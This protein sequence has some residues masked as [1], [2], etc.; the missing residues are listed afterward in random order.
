MKRIWLAAAMAAFG[1]EYVDSGVPLTRCTDKLVP[2]YMHGKITGIRG[3]LLIDAPRTNFSQKN[4][5]Y[6]SGEECFKLDVNSSGEA[7]LSFPSPLP[8]PYAKNPRDALRLGFCINP[9][10]RRPRSTSR[11]GSSWTRGRSASLRGRN[12]CPSPAGRKWTTTD[13][14]AR[15]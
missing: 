7:T 6:V 11:G 14:S 2:V 13:R 5:R 8:A 15:C 4:A 9:A 10:P 3:C 1:A 12:F